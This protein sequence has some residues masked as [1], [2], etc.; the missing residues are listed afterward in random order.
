MSR[1][2]RHIGPSAPGCAGLTVASSSPW[3]SRFPFAVSG[4][5]GLLGVGFNNDLGLHL[6]WAEW[7]RSGLGPAPES[8][9]PLGPHALADAV[10]ALPGIG[11]G[12]A[13]VGEIL[14]IGVLTATR[15]VG[16]A[17][18]PAD[19]RAGY[20]P[21]PWSRCP[22]SAPPTTPRAPSRRPPRPSSSSPSPSTSHDLDLGADGPIR[23]GILDVSARRP[24][25]RWRS[26]G[27]SS[28]PTASPGSPGRWLSLVLWAATLPEIRAGA[29]ATSAGPLRCCGRR[30]CCRW[31][32]LAASRRR[33]RWS[34]RSASSTA[35]TRSPARNTYGP[36]S[37]IEALGVWPA[38][39]YR[40]T[41]PAG[42]T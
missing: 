18:R 32:S 42:R 22:T 30:C 26:P 7:L 3:P 5:W 9:Y 21:R 14:A 40:L 27:G 38:A 6:A 35:S 41:P 24:W 39:N 25:C 23:Q 4:R 15:R 11:L 33:R 20:S 16:G 10:A 37:P 2:T 17:R 12:Q 8:G 34:G 19:R 31:S 1:H 13:F 28:S 36:V 29:A